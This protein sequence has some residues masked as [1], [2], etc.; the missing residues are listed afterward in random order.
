MV[1][2]VGSFAMDE[3]LRLPAI[4]ASA[5]IMALLQACDETITARD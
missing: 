1:A 4:K 2:N 3:K 5:Q